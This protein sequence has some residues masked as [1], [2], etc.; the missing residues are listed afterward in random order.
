[1]LYWGVH[2]PLW[3]PP[4]ERH[5]EDKHTV[6]VVKSKFWFVRLTT[7]AM[8]TSYGLCGER[9]KWRRMPSRAR[10]KRLM[11]TW[12]CNWKKDLRLSS[13]MFWNRPIYNEVTIQGTLQYNLCL[14]FNCVFRTKSTYSFILRNWDSQPLANLNGKTTICDV[15][16]FVNSQHLPM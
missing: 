3:F 9:R 5:S 15:I 4:C 12:W 14:I 1:M 2:Q 16:S 7:F 13:T 8:F 10:P 6:V 11:S